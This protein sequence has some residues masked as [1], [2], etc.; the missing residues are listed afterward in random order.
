ME[1][2]IDIFDYRS[3]FKVLG[4]LVL[5]ETILRKGKKICE[6]ARGRTSNFIS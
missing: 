4:H 5:I 3:H 6:I 2:E 1:A